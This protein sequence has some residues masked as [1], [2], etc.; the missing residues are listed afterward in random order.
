[1][2]LTHYYLLPH[3]LSLSNKL[4]D[5]WWEDILG[6]DYEYAEFFWDN[7]GKSS[8]RGVLLLIFCEC[9]TPFSLLCARTKWM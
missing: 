7:P 8:I 3:F 5:F 4:K 2:E 1:M 9:I 6:T